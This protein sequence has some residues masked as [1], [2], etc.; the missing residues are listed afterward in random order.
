MLVTGEPVVQTQG[1]AAGPSRVRLS[2]RPNPCW[3]LLLAGLGATHCHGF[4]LKRVSI[5]SSPGA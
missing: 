3:G 5:Y 2:C 4:S 1:L